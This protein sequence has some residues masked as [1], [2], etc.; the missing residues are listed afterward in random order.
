MADPQLLLLL[1]GLGLSEN[2]SRVYLGALS[3]G[4]TT[5]QRIAQAAE[6]KR[7]TFYAVVESLQRQGL[8]NVEIRGFKRCFAAAHPEKLAVIIEQRRRELEGGI[9]QLTALFDAKSGASSIKHYQG[10][11]GIKGVYESMIRDI[12]PGENYSVVSDIDQ[13]LALDRDFFLDFFERRGKL[14][15]NI[16]VLLACTKG[17]R[18]HK[19][20]GQPYNMQIRLLPEET[21]LTT[22]L[23]IIPERVMI[24]QLVPPIMAMV[25]ENRHI[26]QMHSELFEILWNGAQ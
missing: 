15:I 26:I 25:V 2:E 12:R 11:T 13:V 23:V 17:A 7:T 6:I 22:N 16:R 8:M 18:E 21:T 14:S 24:H 10:L 5:A 3:L 1:S 4:P 19:K 20:H 9:P